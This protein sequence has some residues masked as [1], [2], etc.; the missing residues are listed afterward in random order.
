[1]CSDMGL[2]WDQFLIQ[3]QKVMVVQIIY[4]ESAVLLA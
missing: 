4:F 2:I 3:E 1:M